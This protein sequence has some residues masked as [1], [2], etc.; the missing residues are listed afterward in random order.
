MLSRCRHSCR[1]A[2]AP[3]FETFEFASICSIGL[4]RPLL[5]C[6]IG[7][8]QV[9]AQMLEF[10]DSLVPGKSFLG[11]PTTQLAARISSLA[12][13]MLSVSY[14]SR[15]QAIRPPL[16]GICDVDAQIRRKGRMRW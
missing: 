6:G 8:R 11:V 3:C 2:V 13:Q 5:L 7:M 16:S 10:N 4:I 14:S 9:H 15:A 1:E 12:T